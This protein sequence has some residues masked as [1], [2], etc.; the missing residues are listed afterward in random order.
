MISC[1]GFDVVNV[2]PH[3]NGYPEVT[4]ASIK[5]H[6]IGHLFFSSEPYEFNREEGEHVADEV[7]AIGG[8]RPLVHLIDGE[9]L[10]WMGSH[11]NEGLKH[12]LNLR[13]ELGLHR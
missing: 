3:G 1:L 10:T 12:L 4:P 11:T 2:D 5:Q 13:G 9:A 6:D 7:E 8:K